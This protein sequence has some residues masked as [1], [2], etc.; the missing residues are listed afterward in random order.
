MKNIVKK[1]LF[2]LLEKS[3]VIIKQP[4]LCFFFLLTINGFLWASTNKGIFCFDPETHQVRTYDEEK[5]LQGSLFN[6]AAH[7]LSKTGELYFGG[8][9]GFTV[10]NSRDIKSNA[11]P[12]ACRNY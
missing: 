8:T 11:P 5:G 4:W 9:N 1:P 12:S 2:F 6:I 3:L 7:Y 10:F